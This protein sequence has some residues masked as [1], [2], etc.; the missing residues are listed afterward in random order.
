MWSL[1]SLPPRERET[2]MAGGG[3][4][5]KFLIFA[6]GHNKITKIWWPDTEHGKK[7]EGG[8]AEKS[9]TVMWHPLIFSDV[10]KLFHRKLVL[11]S[12]SVYRKLKAQEKKKYLKKHYLSPNLNCLNGD[13]HTINIWPTPPPRPFQY[14]FVFEIYHRLGRHSVIQNSLSERMNFFSAPFPWSFFF[15]ILDHF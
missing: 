3:L 5:Q 7:E 1:C 13:H 15:Q 12:D 14:F 9:P 8:C 4:W 10:P 6:R 11:E 2:H